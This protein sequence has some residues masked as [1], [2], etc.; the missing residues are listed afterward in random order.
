[1]SSQGPDSSLLAP[2]LI[3]PAVEC[4]CVRDSVPLWC[5]S[6]LP[7]PPGAHPSSRPPSGPAPPSPSLLPFPQGPVLPSFVS[8]GSGG[9]LPCSTH[10]LPMGS[11]CYGG[12][13]QSHI[14]SLVDCRP[15]LHTSFVPDRRS[16]PS[17][18]TIQAAMPA[19]ADSIRTRQGTE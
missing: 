17:L 6:L 10:K 8:T 3:S 14:Y 9:W 7:S 1:M 15:D 13:S 16:P 18:R 5:H 19:R 2:C 12:F 11:Y 4:H